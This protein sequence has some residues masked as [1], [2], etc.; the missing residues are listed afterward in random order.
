MTNSQS[1][2]QISIVEHLDVVIQEIIKMDKKLSEWSKDPNRKPFSSDDVA[3]GSVLGNRTITRLGAQNL[4]DAA[5]KLLEK[6]ALQ[7]R[8]TVDTARKCLDQELK[9]EVERSRVKGKFSFHAVENRA[10]DALKNVKTFSGV[11]IFPAF[12]SWRS[13]PTDLQ[14]GPVRLISRDVFESEFGKIVDTDLQR[15]SS[16]DDGSSKTQLHLL[17]KWKDLSAPYPYVLAVRISGFELELGRPAAR[18]AA[19]FVLN[20]LR[21]MAR[22]RDGRAIRLSGDT[23]PETEQAFLALTEFGDLVASLSSSGEGALLPDEWARTLL[24]HIG[25]AKHMI[26]TL[27]EKLVDG[28]PYIDPVVERIRYADQLLTEAFQ[29]ASPRLALV[30]FVSALEALAVLPKDRKAQTLAIRCALVSSYGDADYFEAVRTVVGRAYHVRNDVVH[31]DA[32]EPYEASRAI[33]NLQPY[34]FQIL[35]HLWR[36]LV[37]VR[38]EERPNSVRKLRKSV[39]AAYAAEQLLVEGVWAKHG[40]PNPLTEREEGPGF[41]LRVKMKLAKV[42]SKLRLS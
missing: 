15:A 9:V 29:D 4:W 38:N 42:M 32:P 36:T 8:I 10:S 27:V 12:I 35:L 13:E 40:I 14:F 41:V 24:E 16:G 25:D 20:L 17:S 33:N 6:E 7:A 28:E 3:L 31:G 21:L 5:E 2:R 1:N 22:R 34:L 26:D 23:R 18:Q 30:K 37:L 39:N 11:C 19:E